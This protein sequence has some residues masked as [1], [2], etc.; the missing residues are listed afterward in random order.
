MNK[1]TE[2]IIRIICLIVLIILI[3]LVYLNGIKLDCNK[4]YINFNNEFNKVKINFSVSINDLYNSYLN[5][6]CIVKYQDN[7]FIHNVIK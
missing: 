5:N 1:N 6:D 2:I 4:C 7:Q 3:V